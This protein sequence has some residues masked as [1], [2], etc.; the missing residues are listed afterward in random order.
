MAVS[1]IKRGD[2]VTFLDVID[3]CNSCLA[4]L[5]DKQSTRCPSRRVFG[6]TCSADLS[7]IR[8]LL[9]GWSSFIYL[10]PNTKIIKL[11]Q[12]LSP[13]VFMS[14]GCG[15]P[16][17]LHAVD[18]GNIRLMDR[19]IVQGSGPVGLLAAL[20]AQASGALQVIVIGAPAHRL[21][22]VKKFGIK[23]TI[24]L[25][26]CRTPLERQGMVKEFTGGRLADVVIEATGRPE[27]VAE[28]LELCRDGGTYVVVGQYT[29]N[30]SV[31]INPHFQIN[32]KHITIK[33]SWGSDFS[34][35]Y[36]G[37]QFMA[38]MVHLPW[39]LVVSRMYELKDAPEALAS[40]EKLEVFKA[41]IDPGTLCE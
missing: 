31:D 35:F 29:D 12:N 17:A 8:G 30:G 11:P 5:V 16:T 26:D 22:V 33:G 21:E 32:R 6:I 28:G 25:E 40:V 34:H 3:S 15:L 19:V 7:S 41:L 1:Q 36:R 24:N 39:D 37:V 4:C 9:G 23:H 18:R 27:A 20:F 13:R 38:Q 2:V 10:P 14:G